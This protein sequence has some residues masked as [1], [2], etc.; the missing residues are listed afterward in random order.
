MFPME[1]SSEVHTCDLLARILH[2][3]VDLPQSRNLL[4]VGY[5]ACSHVHMQDDDHDKSFIVAL[6]TRTCRALIYLHASL[7]AMQ[8][9]LH[10]QRALA[11]AAPSTTGSR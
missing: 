4:V 11:T 5:A 2:E 9:A 1:T 6:K 7:Q 8:A 10:T 3:L